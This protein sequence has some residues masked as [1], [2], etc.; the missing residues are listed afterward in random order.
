MNE[1]IESKLS[2]HDSQEQEF[3]TLM[4]KNTIKMEA[5][6]QK[7]YEFNEY[8]LNLIYSNMKKIKDYAIKKINVTITETKRIEDLDLYI[9]HIYLQELITE[10]DKNT[11]PELSFITSLSRLTVKKLND[12]EI[13]AFYKIHFEDAL[14]SFNN[15]EAYTKNRKNSRKIKGNF[16]I[17]DLSDVW[18]DKSLPK[19][20]EVPG[21]NYDG[22]KE[23]M[24]NEII[25][26]AQKSNLPL[27]NYEISKIYL[28]LN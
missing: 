19:D 5:L 6:L 9:Q 1:N 22:T 7:N 24:T 2:N 20:C 18:N 13:K 11:N 8:D 25:Q 28:E 3:R 26:Q 14:E 16:V 23:L 4:K 10:L 15:T 27:M 12:A 21:E 17:L